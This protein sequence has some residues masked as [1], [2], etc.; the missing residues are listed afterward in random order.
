MSHDTAMNRVLLARHDKRPYGLDW[1]ERIFTAP[2]LHG[3]RKRRRRSTVGGFAWLGD[4]P[5]WSRSAEGTP[6]A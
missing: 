3:D 5:V 2:E 4:Q 6:D 1:I